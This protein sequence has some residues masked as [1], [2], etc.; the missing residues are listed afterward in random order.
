MT[1]EANARV[2]LDAMAKAARGARA[3]ASRDLLEELIAAHNIKAPEI[4][5]AIDF[6]IHQGWFNRSRTG[7][8]SLTNTGL[9]AAGMDPPPDR[10]T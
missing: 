8:L 5:A 2:V 9:K 4:K 1:A 10:Q 6:G 3:N 7:A